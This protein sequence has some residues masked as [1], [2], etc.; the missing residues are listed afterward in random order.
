MKTINGVERRDAHHAGNS[1]RQGGND[2]PLTVIHET[3]FSTRWDPVMS[4]NDDRGSAHRHELTDIE[5]GEPV[6]ALSGARGTQ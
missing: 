5:R 2:Q 4:I 6:G 3:W 1:G